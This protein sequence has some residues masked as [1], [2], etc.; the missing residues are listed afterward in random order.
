MTHNEEQRI[1]TL[2]QMGIL[3]SEPE[4]RFDRVT[5]LARRLFNV[6]IAL[7]TLVDEKRQWFKSNFGLE[8][9]K[10]TARDV[11]F[12]GHAILGD[13]PFIIN[14][15][16]NDERF[17]DN[18]AVVN[19]PHVRFYAGVPL[20]FED[21]SKLGTLCIIDTEP[22][23]LDHNQITD[24][25]DLA[26]IAER[27]LA[28]TH[29]ASV[30]ELTQISNRR[31]FMSLVAKSLARCRLRNLPFCLAFFDLNGFKQINDKWGH[32]IGDDALQD[33]AQLMLKSFRD[34]DLLA[35]LGG[36]EF[37]LFM[38]SV[39]LVDA[40][41]IIE[42]FRQEVIKFNQTAGRPYQLAFCSGIVASSHCCNMSIDELLEQADQVMYR[43]KV[44]S[45]AAKEHE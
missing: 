34:S 10:E 35:R 13:G 5:R 45:R 40:E 2:H 12:C 36:D 30:D 1:T 41:E 8:G 23:H 18:P 38:S 4:E 17:F 3:D 11:S 25:I 21:G 32:A 27:E 20:V 31:G 39:S 33:F 42:R 6:P 43:Q 44:R 29:N 37:V 9:E 15:A 24:L 14:N 22:R 26:K 16:Q 19:N 28:A 7:V